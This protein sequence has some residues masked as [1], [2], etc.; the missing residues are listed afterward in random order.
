[1]RSAEALKLVW[2]ERNG[3][4]VTVP[5]RTGFGHIVIKRMVEQAVQGTV[6]LNFAGEGLQWSLLAPESVFLQ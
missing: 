1:M 6:E 5:K 4:L 2:R 3:P